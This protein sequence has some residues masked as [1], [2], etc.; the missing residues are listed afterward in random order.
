MTGDK[1]QAQSVNPIPSEGPSKM[2]TP[3]P[4]KSKQ[5]MSEKS[6]SKSKTNQ[7]NQEEKKKRGTRHGPKI[8]EEYLQKRIAEYHASQQ[9]EQLRQRK[10]AQQQKERNN[11]GGHGAGHSGGHSGLSG[12]SGHR[13]NDGTVHMLPS[14]P[15]HPQKP[16][17]VLRAS[18]HYSGQNNMTNNLTQGRDTAGLPPPEIGQGHQPQYVARSGSANVQWTNPRLSGHS[19]QMHSGQFGKGYIPPNG[20]RIDRGS[21]GYYPPNLP[22]RT[23][24]R[25]SGH[26]SGL[27]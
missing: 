13:A 12:H 1:L 20:M 5:G 18:S 3:E 16:R 25:S 27:E 10:A 6:V 21:N 2:D 4:V 7:R 22:D 9:R 11:G 19:G 15:T 17:T 24:A 8:L 26:A 14:M 23:S